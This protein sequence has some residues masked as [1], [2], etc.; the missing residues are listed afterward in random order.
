MRVSEGAITFTRTGASSAASDSA[1]PSTAAFAAAIAAWF[2]NPARA[3]TE[4]NSTTAPGPAASAGAAACTAS[5][6]PTAFSRKASIM[7]ASVVWARGFSTIE[8]TQ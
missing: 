8:P 4:E 2:G 1:I 6:A 3:A 7:S 5:R